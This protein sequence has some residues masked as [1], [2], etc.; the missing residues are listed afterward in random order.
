MSTNRHIFRCVV[1]I[2]SQIL[3]Q[4]VRVHKASLLSI[5]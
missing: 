1:E 2:M 3:V 5:C 4:V